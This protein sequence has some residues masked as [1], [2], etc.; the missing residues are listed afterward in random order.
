MVESFE[1]FIKDVLAGSYCINKKIP[2]EI[3]A[4]HL[5]LHGISVGYGT[6]KNSIKAILLLDYVSFIISLH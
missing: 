5:I 6:K 2:E 4:R 3:F 1:N